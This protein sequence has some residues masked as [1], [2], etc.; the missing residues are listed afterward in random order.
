MILDIQI[1]SM[2]AI[3]LVAATVVSAG[4]TTRAHAL[5]PAQ[6]ATLAAKARADALARAR[7][8][9]A[10]KARAD[11]LAKATA[12]A[13]RRSKAVVI[14]RQNVEAETK[15]RA[16]AAEKAAQAQAQIQ[17]ASSRLPTKPGD[18]ARFVQAPVQSPRKLQISAVQPLQASRPQIAPASRAHSAA[19]K[20][21]A[22]AG[23]RSSHAR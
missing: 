4:L 15:R 9:A 19:G 17:T 5:T 20:A 12:D 7:V 2:F 10:A 18:R 22:L 6:S 16:Q 1:R 23:K 14:A 8:Q 11:A 13:A 21:S 3:G